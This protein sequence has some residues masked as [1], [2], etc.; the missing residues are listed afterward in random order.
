[1]VGERYNNWTIIGNADDRI[2]SAGKHHKRVLCACDCGRTIIEKDLYK[3]KHG[4]K[5]CKKCYLEILPNNGVQFEYKQ[6][7]YEI[8]EDMVI[9]HINNSDTVFYIDIDDYEKIKDHCWCLN[10][11]GRVT[12]TINGKKVFLS[13]YIMCCDDKNFVVDHINRN[14]LDNRKCNL[15]ICTQTDNTKNKS[16][17]KNN[18]SGHSGVYYNKRD[19]IWCAYINCK[20]K[21]YYL[22][23]YKT[24]E[25]AI[26]IR[27]KYEKEFFGEFAPT[28]N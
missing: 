1:M 24:K 6:N 8:L 10:G 9:G 12:S 7:E 28:N 5:M 19:K 14:P 21:G 16:L 27:E 15:R 13:R 26:E 2:D 23:Q 4:A 25:E 20:N 11:Y 18:K 17:Y 3:L 22:G